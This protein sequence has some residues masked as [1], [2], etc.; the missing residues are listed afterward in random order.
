MPRPAFVCQH[1]GEK[2]QPLGTGRLPKWC[3]ECR[4]KR[5][6]ARKTLT[7]KNEM[8]NCVDCGRDIRRASWHHLRC[9]GCRTKKNLERANARYSARYQRVTVDTTCSGCGRLFR[10]RPDKT[11]CYA[12]HKTPSRVA[13]LFNPRRFKFC[14]CGRGFIDWSKQLHQKLC[15]ACHV[16]ARAATMARAQQKRRQKVFEEQITARAIAEVWRELQAVSRPAKTA[17]D[18]VMSC[19]DCGRVIERRGNKHLRCSECAL[20]RNRRRARENARHKALIRRSARPPRV[21]TLVISCAD[22]GR[23]IERRAENHLRC[24]DCSRKRGHRRA[25]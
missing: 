21:L 13:Y 10:S 7:V 3:P 5:H 14:R 24:S 2:F 18:V 17:L 22:C 25:S 4:T 9:S 12:C 1:C 6:G 20:E 15:P 23:T 8:M 11:L 19:A 16:T